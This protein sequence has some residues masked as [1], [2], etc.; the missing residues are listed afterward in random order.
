MND[1]LRTLRRDLAATLPNTA[2][3]IV[4]KR[5]RLFLPDPIGDIGIAVA[6]DGSAFAVGDP[7]VRRHVGDRTPAY[8]AEV[9]R[10]LRWHVSAQLEKARMAG[11]FSADAREHYAALLRAVAATD[12]ASV[13]DDILAEKLAAHNQNRE[14]VAKRYAAHLADLDRDGAAITTLRAELRALN[15]APKETP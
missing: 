2:I 4:G 11:N 15:P 14:A 10:Y 13:A 6:D 5:L 3:S 1:T 9:L 8:P 7:D 12:F